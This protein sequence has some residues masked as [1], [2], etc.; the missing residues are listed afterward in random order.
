MHVLPKTNVAN[1]NFIERVV[2][3]ALFAS[4]ALQGGQ[5]EFV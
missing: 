5:S 2:Q 4:F 1:V 3:V